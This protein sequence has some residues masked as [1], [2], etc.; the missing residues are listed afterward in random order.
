MP[1]KIPA[2]SKFKGDN[3][4]SF[5]QW[6]LQFEA[7]LKALDVKNEG[8][9]WR[10]LLLCCTE[11]SAFAT[12]SNAILADGEISYADLK[13]ELETKYC[14][15]EYKRTLETKLR[16]LVFKPGVN[17]TTFAFEV[18][19]VVQELYGISD[20]NVIDSIA[21]NHVLSQ[22][23]SSIQEPV[24]LLQ[25]TGKCTLESLLELINSKAADNPYNIATAKAS[26]ETAATSYSSNDRVDRLE[27]MV[28]KLCFRMDEMS[29][30][31]EACSNCGAN[32]HD[33][34]RCYKL[35]ICYQCG[36]KG[37]ISKHCRKKRENSHAPK[38]GRVSSSAGRMTEEN[39][40]NV[41]NGFALKPVPRIMLKL[42]I[43][44]SDMDILYDPGSM[45]TMITRCA[46]DELKIKPP[47][48]PVNRSGIGISGETFRLDGVAYLN[49]KFLREDGTS[50]ILEYQPVLV[51][52][53]ISSN[54]LGMD[55][56]LNFK[57]AVRDHFNDLI[58]FV[59]WSGDQVV[60]KYWKEKK[61]TNTA[62]VHVAKATIIPA[63]SIK[64][65]PSKIINSKKDVLKDAPCVFEPIKESRDGLELSDVF[66]QSASKVVDLPVLNDSSE[67]MLLSKG[68]VLG[69]INSEEQAQETIFRNNA[70]NALAVH[71]STLSEDELSP[72]LQHLDEVTRSTVVRILTG[73]QKNLTK[74]P[75]VSHAHHEIHLKDNVPVSQPARRLPY[76]QRKEILSQIDELL[77]NDIIEPSTSPYSSPIVTVKKKDGSYRMC[78]DY[79]ALK[80]K[81][82]SIYVSYSK[83]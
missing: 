82:C 15:A 47:L 81:N 63:E 74:V 14:G 76:N 25:L 66:L 50:Y 52:S 26:F 60:I 13:H 45:Y 23:D 73:Y 12:V 71:E 65:V 42:N 68:E 29:K 10:D 20:G 44:G 75:V 32:G 48:V 80:F 38:N 59:P 77:E 55:T 37:H 2:I 69:V 78:V 21:Q 53:A 43:V 4:L 64:M 33:R 58:T 41:E 35:K 72:K 79:R 22:L 57:G 39:Q 70:P 28:E 49:I 34:S 11:A 17:I 18:E 1:G 19:S 83:N 40:I 3:S 5:R 16:S 27:K 30:G 36:M 62:Y 61:D 54:V 31:A 7:Q 8:T 46:Y 51:S 67:D 6:S 24:K 56:E 9:K